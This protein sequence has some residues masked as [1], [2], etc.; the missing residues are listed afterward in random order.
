MPRSRYR[1]TLESGPSLDLNWLAR[2]GFVKPGAMSGPVRIKWTD[3]Y[4]DEEVASGIV[5]ADM[6]GTRVGWLNIHI[7]EGL[8]QKITLVPCRRNFGGYQ[9]F[10][11]C[12]RLGCRA[13]VLW[14]P[15]GAR[16]FA[17]R[18]AW[19]RQVAYSSQFETQ[20]DR[21]H[22]GKKKINSR[23]CRMGGFDPEEWDLPPKPKWMRWSTYNRAVEKFDHYEAIL[24]ISIL[25]VA[26]RLGFNGRK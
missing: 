18:Q 3:S 6:S 1:A 5:V 23:L 2:R 22:R 15:P 26:T 24:D 20:V 12:P 9:W 21:A 10:F 16:F 8:D 7:N 13:S 25:A 14:M 17:C 4:F 11:L 19:G